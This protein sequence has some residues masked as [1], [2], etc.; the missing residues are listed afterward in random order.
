M[1]MDSILAYNAGDLQESERCIRDAVQTKL[2]EHF[3]SILAP[4][5][6]PDEEC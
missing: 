4:K 5:Y 6:C 2:T 1:I 3:E